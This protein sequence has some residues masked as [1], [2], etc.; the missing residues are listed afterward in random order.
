ME[1]TRAPITSK[2]NG[3]L[4]HNLRQIFLHTSE[5]LLPL[6]ASSHELLSHKSEWIPS[7]TD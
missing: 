3:G 6:T 1:D 4:M 7:H 5:R 2:T